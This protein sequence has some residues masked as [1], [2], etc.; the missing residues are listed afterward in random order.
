[1]NQKYVKKNIAPPILLNSHSINMFL[2]KKKNYK[3]DPIF[4]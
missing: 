3:V 1:M 4:D 2:V